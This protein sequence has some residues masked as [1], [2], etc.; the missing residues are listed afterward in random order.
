MAHHVFR[1][2]L[3]DSSV[4]V[5]H[6]FKVHACS[7]AQVVLNVLWALRREPKRLGHVILLLQGWL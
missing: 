7:F 4:S 5:G 3:V 2:N 1:R 6:A